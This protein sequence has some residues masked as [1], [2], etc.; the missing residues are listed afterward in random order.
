MQI[1]PNVYMCVY[2]LHA[3]VRVAMVVLLLVFPSPYLFFRACCIGLQALMY[4]HT[5]TELVCSN[6]GTRSAVAFSPLRFVGFPE[7]D[8]HTPRHNLSA[9]VTVVQ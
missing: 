4:T 7:R 8:T 3:A 5:Q 9:V 6:S 1:R 2:V